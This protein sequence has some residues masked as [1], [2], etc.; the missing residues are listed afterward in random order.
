MTGA[1][2]NSIGETTALAIAKAGPALLILASRTPSKLDA[3]AKGCREAAPAKVRGEEREKERD[4]TE[5]ET[6]K[7]GSLA[8]QPNLRTWQ[9][10]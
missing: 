9:T 8:C 1:S 6:K 2:P 10:S 3:A 5:P 7:N 4:Q